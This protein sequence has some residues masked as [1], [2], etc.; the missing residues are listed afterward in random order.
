MVM[1]IAQ[2][3]SRLFGPESQAIYLSPC[4]YLSISNTSVFVYLCNR[5]YYHHS[6][7]SYSI[8]NMYI[9]IIITFMYLCIIVDLIVVIVNYLYLFI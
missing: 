3:F 9:T 1:W 6:A 4:M 5:Y 8:L 7:Y 2:N